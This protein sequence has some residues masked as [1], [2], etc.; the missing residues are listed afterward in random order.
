MITVDGKQLRNLEEQVQYLTQQHNID[1]GISE[2]GIRVLGRL[3]TA[4]EL[5]DKVGN[6]FGDAYAIGTEPPYDFYIWTRV[7]TTP[8]AGEWFNYGN[9]SIVGPEG[10]R[11]EKGDKGDTGIRG[12]RWFSGTGQPTTT[13]GYMAYDYYINVAT[14]NI[15]HLHELEGGILQWQLEGNI[16]GPEGR[17]GVQGI[18][19][20]QGERGEQGIQ[21]VPGPAG[22]IVDLVGIIPDVSQLP[23]GAAAIEEFVA[24]YGRQGAYLV[25]EPKM[26]YALTGPDSN[27]QWEELGMFGGGTLVTVGGNFQ[28][29]WDAD[30]KLDAYTTTGGGNK[31]YGVNNEGEQ[32]M[33]TIRPDPQ[34]T[35]STYKN[36]VVQYDIT[37]G[38]N[39]NNGLIR[40]A[41]T[42]LQPYHTA[43]KAYV[44]ALYRHNLY[45]ACNLYGDTAYIRFTIYTKDSFA[46]STSTIPTIGLITA[47]GYMSLSTNIYTVYEADLDIKNSSMQITGFDANGGTVIQGFDS[48][49][50][51]L[52]DNV[53]KI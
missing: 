12:S 38:K 2:W 1:K 21:G 19:G 41:E 36:Q 11:G 14:G 7:P 28:T 24:T 17:Q 3:D 4:E 32:K 53:K 39:T 45:L 40:I 25:G 44:D 37:S 51:T 27:L 52:T 16:K 43:S 35:S 9:I 46:Y 49:A 22:P 23:T 10:P 42:P 48:A 18:Q 31:V 30:T 47:T 5:E 34:T 33:Y 8:D 26:V 13:S 15:W 20:K 6:Q 50:Y 29:E